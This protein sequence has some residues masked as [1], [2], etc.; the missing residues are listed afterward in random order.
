MT[1][2]EALDYVKCDVLS[3]RELFYKF[4]T[5]LEKADIS[6]TQRPTIGSCMA[7]FNSKLYKEATGKNYKDTTAP[8]I[9]KDMHDFVRQSL[10]AGR[11]ESLNGTQLIE[12]P[13][14]S[15]DV[16]SLYPSVMGGCS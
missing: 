4:Q 13:V 5:E 14:A 1:E 10:V 7:S 16:V 2:D 11:A 9:D 8:N 6:L 3:L 12:K 15:A